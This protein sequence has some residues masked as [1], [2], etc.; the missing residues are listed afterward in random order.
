VA[1]GHVGEPVEVH[2]LVAGRDDAHARQLVSTEPRRA[3]GRQHPE[4]RGADDGASGQRDLAGLQLSALE[5]NVLAKVAAR[6]NRDL[7]GSTVGILDADHGVG[8]AGH[9]RPGHDPH[10]G[11]RRQ[12]VGD[13]RAGGD[14]A[15]DWQRTRE[16]G[17]ILRAHRIAIHS[18]VVP[19]GKD[20]RTLHVG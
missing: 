17:Q 6:P 16:T 10:R 19:R 1:V 11:A 12:L 5:A 4:L 2:Q 18:G 9:R 7:G 13:A 15:R 20:N 8:A 3:D 14:H